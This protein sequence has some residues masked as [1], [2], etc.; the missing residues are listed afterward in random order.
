MPRDRSSR[1][2]PPRSRRACSSPS[3]LDTYAARSPAR[4]ATAG[5]YSNPRTAA[6]S[7]W[8]RWVTC[9]GH[10]APAAA[11]AAGAG[12]HA[13]GVDAGGA[14]RRARGCRNQPRPSRRDGSGSL[15]RR[16]VLQAE[17]RAYRVAAPAREKGGHPAARRRILPR[18]GPTPA[19]GLLT[20]RDEV[21]AGPY[22]AGQRERALRRARERSH[23]GRRSRHRGE[24]L[25]R[26]SPRTRRLGAEPGALS[27]RAPV[28]GRA[29]KR[30]RV[31]L[32]RRE[33]RATR[34]RTDS[35]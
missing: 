6:R 22:L 2:T 27:T 30:S 1:S 10:A 31:R 18:G 16:P 23:S 8:T 28:R 14:D 7:C 5:A 35:E 29:H 21:V 24:A 11:R 13:G 4:Y 19:L 15:P 17:C 3:S 20:T 33:A 32:R 9:L 12:D 26:R 34:R 25:A